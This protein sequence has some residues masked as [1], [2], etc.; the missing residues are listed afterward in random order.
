[1]TWHG[2]T[3]RSKEAERA[4]P[5][6]SGL[7]TTTGPEGRGAEQPPKEQRPVLS[8]GRTDPEEEGSVTS[9]N[10]KTPWLTATGIDNSNHDRTDV[11]PTTGPQTQ[12]SEVKETDPAVSQSLRR[13]APLRPTTNMSDQALQHMSVIKK[14]SPKRSEITK[15]N[16][17]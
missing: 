10:L 16:D 17:V 4:D 5:P 6:V 1:M 14:R 3:R 15:K 9:Q 11:R 2:S 8:L 7:S 13:A 12:K